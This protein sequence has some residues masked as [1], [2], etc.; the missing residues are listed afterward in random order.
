MLKTAGELDDIALLRIIALNGKGL[1]IIPRL[2]VVNDI[3][4]GSLIVLHEF[5]SI[6]Q[7]FYAITRQKKFPNPIINELV[8]SF[9]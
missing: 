6:K 8:R 5:K 7:S 9:L 4:N 2:G 1:V 3:D